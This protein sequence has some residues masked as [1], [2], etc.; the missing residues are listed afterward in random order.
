MA[1]FVV[2]QAGFYIQGVAAAIVATA[3]SK[4]ASAVVTATHDLA[5]NDYVYIEGTGWPSLDGKVAKV[6]AVTGT[7]AFTININTT[8]ETATLTPLTSA[9]YGQYAADWI[10]NCLSG[11]D[12]AGGASDSVSVGTFCNSADALAGAASASTM[13]LTGF[14]DPAYAGY[15][16]LVNASLDGLPRWFKFVM[17]QAANPNGAIQPFMLLK[18]TCGAVDQ[19]F[20]VGAAATYTCQVTL[21]ETPVIVL[22]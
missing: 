17:P 13:T 14:V 10:E 3:I 22:A 21:S 15:Q 20:Q 6:T 8:A 16:E 9:F 5:V 19:S 1:K 18:G 2:K 12:V 4:A 11:L 7:T